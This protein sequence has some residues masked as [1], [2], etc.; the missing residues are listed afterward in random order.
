MLVVKYS[1]EQYQDFVCDFLTRYYISTGQQITIVTKASLVVKLW[2]ADLTG[3]VKL[4]KNRYSRANRGIP[5]KD[6]VALLRSL[7]LMTF[8]GETSIPKWVDSLR[9]DPF[10]AV[11]S[12]FCPPA[13]LLL[14]LMMFRQILSR[15]W[16]LFII[17]WIG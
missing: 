6:A 2:G 3:I 16:V 13:F 8:T 7:I 11:L 15:A 1:H 10:L 12:G 4:I 5:P 14:K 9:S 17:I